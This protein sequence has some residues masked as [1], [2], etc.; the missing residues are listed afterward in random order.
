MNNPKL[1]LEEG[2]NAYSDGD[3]ERALKIFKTLAEQGDAKAQNNLGILYQQGHG[4]PKDFE[5]AEKED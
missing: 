1:T 5:E 3:Y 2:R 4:V